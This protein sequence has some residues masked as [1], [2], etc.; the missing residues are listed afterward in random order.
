MARFGVRQQQKP[1]RQYKDMTHEEGGMPPSVLQHSF[2]LGLVVLPMGIRSHFLLSDVFIFLIPSGPS[3]TQSHRHFTGCCDPDL[4]GF[5]SC[6]YVVCIDLCYLSC[7]LSY[8]VRMLYWVT[9]YLYESSQA[10]SILFEF[11]CSCLLAEQSSSTAK[12]SRKRTN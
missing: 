4:S 7:A 10:S 5:L 3:M 2:L 12:L 9:I 6:F 8:I 1:P 11:N